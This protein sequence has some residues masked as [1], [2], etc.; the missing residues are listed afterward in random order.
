VGTAVTFWGAQW[1]KLNALSG[2]ASP[3]AFKGF[4]NAPATVT[5]GTSWSASPG[6]SLPPPAGPLPAYLAVIVASSIGKSGSTISG[7]TPHMVVVKTSPGYAP[8]PAHAGAG[9]VVAQIC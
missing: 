9:T 4:E 7:N 2:G 5:C 3:A 6:N 1:S 8:D